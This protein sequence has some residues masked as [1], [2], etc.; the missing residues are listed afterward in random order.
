ML[1]F[2][3]LLSPNPTGKIDKT[4]GRYYLG[5]LPEKILPDVMELDNS[6]TSSIS[7]EMEEFEERSFMYIPFL[8]HRGLNSMS[9]R[10]FF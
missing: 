5:G 9:Y 1:C 6:G 8:F 2:A 4:T 10:E 3:C 7:N